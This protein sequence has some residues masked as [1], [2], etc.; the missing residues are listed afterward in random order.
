MLGGDPTQSVSSLPAVA[1]PSQGVA[2][3]MVV[4]E[5]DGWVCDNDDDVATI[6]H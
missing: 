4:W 5:V 6:Q 3:N 1:M 2:M